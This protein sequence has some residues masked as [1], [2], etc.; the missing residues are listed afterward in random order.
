MKL[1]LLQQLSALIFTTVIFLYFL[2]AE[3]S[4]FPGTIREK[5]NNVEVWAYPDVSKQKSSITTNAIRRLHEYFQAHGVELSRY[6]PKL[7]LVRNDADYKNELLMAST[8]IYRNYATVSQKAKMSGGY[9]F[10]SA[11]IIK[12]HDNM[13]DERVAFVTSH[14][15]AHE[16]QNLMSPRTRQHI[17]QWYIEGTADFWGVMAVTELNPTANSAIQKRYL[18]ILKEEK[19][20]PLLLLLKTNTEWNYVRI[21]AKNS[22]ITY[23]FAYQAV[24]RLADSYGSD[25]L[26]ELFRT[27]EERNRK[28][29]Y[30]FE[31]AF[32]DVF[33]LSTDQFVQQY[34]K[35]LERLGITI[36]TA[37]ILPAKLA[38]APSVPDEEP[39]PLEPTYKSYRESWKPTF[40]L[41][42]FD[43]IAPPPGMNWRGNAQEWV[44]KAEQAGWKVMRDP[45]QPAVGAILV[46]SNSATNIVW[47]GI[48][49]EVANGQIQVEFMGNKNTPEIDKMTFTELSKKN[50][51]GYILPE[52]L[53]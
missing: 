33:G 23:A 9:A 1:R 17:P 8:G 31:Q 49:R 2:P 36:D 20:A 30:P 39:P 4:G 26:L 21:R 18:D 45:A 50:F 27:M 44:D 12:I 34:N 6:A 40:V 13:S 46:R 11:I 19:H 47:I 16:Y 7:L 32:A 5:A 29:R 24:K 42:E 3:A 38:N 25:K 37:P 52:R 15:M 51:V 10:D 53:Q 14:E 35:E 48:I 28:S 41:H 43:I 22:S